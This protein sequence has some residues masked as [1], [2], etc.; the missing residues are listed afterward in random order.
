MAVPMGLALV[1][2]KGPFVSNLII[3]LGPKTNIVLVISIHPMHL[4]T[5]RGNCY[6]NS[7]I[8]WQHNNL[9]SFKTR[10]KAQVTGLTRT[11]WVNFFKNKTMSFLL[12]INK[13]QGVATRFLTGSCQVTGSTRV[14]DQVTWVFAFPYFFKPGQL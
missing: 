14:F 12:K 7:F 6:I 11:S 10:P 3:D 8:T 4:L 1:K 5:K 13:Q 9:C 2:K